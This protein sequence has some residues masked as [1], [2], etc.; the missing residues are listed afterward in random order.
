MAPFENVNF[1]ISKYIL[2][3]KLKLILE[4]NSVFYKKTD[5]GCICEKN[6]PTQP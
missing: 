5:L 6:L 4:T 1:F 2:F 3:L